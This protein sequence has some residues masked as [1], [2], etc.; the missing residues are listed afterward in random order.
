M[1][2][3]PLSTQTPQSSAPIQTHSNAAPAP[4]ASP[5]YERPMTRR[6]YTE[7]KNGFKTSEFYVMLVFVAGVLLSTYADQD[8][9]ARRD[10]WF[11]AALAVGAYIVSR[12]LAKLGTREPYD[13]DR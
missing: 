7:T 3:F 4:T 5:C 8:T 2:E 12:G 1:K 11:F 6:T 13:D 9:L 10:G